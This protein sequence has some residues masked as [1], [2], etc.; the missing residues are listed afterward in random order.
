MSTAKKAILIIL[1][2][3]LLLLAGALGAAYY[4][5]PH[6]GS[7]FVYRMSEH[8]AADD[9][10]SSDL[11]ALLNLSRLTVIDLRGS[12][13][14]AADYDRLRAAY[15]DAELLW[16]VPVNGQRIDCGATS[17]TLKN[18]TEAD[19][20]MLPYLPNLH[21]VRATET[22]CYDALK[23]AEAAYPDVAF[24]WTVREGDI[25]VERDITEFDVTEPIPL[26]TLTALFSKLDDLNTVKLTSSHLSNAQT[27][28][29]I[30]AFPNAA[31]TYRVHLGD[32]L[33]DPD[34]AALKL[35]ASSGVYTPDEVLEAIAGGDQPDPENCK[36]IKCPK[37][38]STKVTFDMLTNEF[39]CQACG[40]IW[41]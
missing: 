15:P 3:V 41:L 13:L 31:F 8:Y 34:L 36:P 23:V 22:D 11:D 10:T 14:S 30:A 35:G 33:V 2:V 16:T 9:L 1:F 40:Y 20:A 12:D 7:G 38:G 29:L 32:T 28:E 19:L 6:V 24:S 17:L 4:L 26:E 27:A 37:C 21:S 18:A 25:T 5:F 39:E